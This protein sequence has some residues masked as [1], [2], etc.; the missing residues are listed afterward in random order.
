M[1]KVLAPFEINIAELDKI[2]VDDKAPTTDLD[3]TNIFYFS[4]IPE[5]Q[6]EQSDD[7]KSLLSTIEDWKAWESTKCEQAVQSKISSKALPSDLSVASRSK[8]I[9]YRAKVLEYIRKQS[10][11]FVQS[12]WI[13]HLLNML[14]RIVNVDTGITEKVSVPDTQPV[15]LAVVNTLIDIEP[16]APNLPYRNFLKAV[17]AAFSFEVELVQPY[18]HTVIGFQYDNVIEKFQAGMCKM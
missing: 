9:A 3:L 15:N 17:G 13:L 2:F 8:R 14:T 6:Q 16:L 18:Y 5:D 1:A 7:L 11:W 10:P 12:I 4:E